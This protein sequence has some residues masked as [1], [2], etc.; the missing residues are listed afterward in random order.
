MKI[1]TAEQFLE[2]PYGVTYIQFI[3]QIYVGELAI[4]SEERGIN[5]WW[6][7]GILPWVVDDEEFEKWRQDKTYKLKTEGFTTDD[8]IYNHED[9]VLYAVFNKEE[10]QGMIDRLQESL[11]TY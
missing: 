7:T 5:S 4:K 2:E 8:A 11:R 9:N 6:S 10:V 3:P 1:L